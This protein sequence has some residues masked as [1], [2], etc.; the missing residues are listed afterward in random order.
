MSRIIRLKIRRTSGWADFT[1][2]VGNQAYVLDALEAV[3]HQDRTLLFQHSCHH[4]SCGSCGVRINGRERLA[5]I[6]LLEDVSPSDQPVRIEPLR[7]LPLLGDLLVDVHPVMDRIETLR[8]PLIRSVEPGLAIGA[9]SFTRFENCIECGLCVSACPI[10]GS[11]PLYWGPAA[12][13]A[14]ERVVAEPR[15]GNAATA[16]EQVNCEQGVWRCHGVFECSEVC[17]A[18]VDPA[19]AIMILRRQLLRGERL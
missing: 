13:A 10:V 15:G 1:V 8:L 7:N 4:G 5:C 18:D 11:D 3:W 16:L 19:R 9:L 17:P 14:A 6:T 12:L 2:A